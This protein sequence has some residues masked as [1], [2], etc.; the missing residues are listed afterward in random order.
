MFYFLCERRNP[1][2]WNY[3]WP[4]D[5]TARDHERFIEEAERDPP[6]VVLLSDQRELDTYAPAIVAY[7][8]AHYIRTDQ[9]G[10]IAIYVRREDD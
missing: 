10:R 1:T 6:A 7:V 2:R 3:L 8:D 4:G 5:Q 9:V